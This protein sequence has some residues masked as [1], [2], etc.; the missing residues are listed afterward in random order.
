MEKKYTITLN[1]KQMR[2]I[3]ECLEEHSRIMCGQFDT[4]HVPALE[5]AMHKELDFDDFIKNRVLI[6]EHLFKAKEL[7]WK[8]LSRNA[9]HGIGYSEES[10]LCYDMYKSIRYCFEQDNKEECLKTGQ[11]YFDNVHSR[12]YHSHTE[13]PQ[14]IVERIPERQI[15]LERIL[16]EE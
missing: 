14:M 16:K 12:E 11:K 1:E 6:N 8:D 4:N 7:I 3:A 5:R 15:K 10:D 13:E 2:L 9:N